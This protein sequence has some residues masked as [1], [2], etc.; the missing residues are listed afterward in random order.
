VL[1][2]LAHAE[3]DVRAAGAL[4]AAELR[5]NADV[6]A[7]GVAAPLTDKFFR[8]TSLKVSHEHFHL[9]FLDE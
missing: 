4:V 2:H 6:S 5:A 7:R 8:P 1:D 9:R 3:E